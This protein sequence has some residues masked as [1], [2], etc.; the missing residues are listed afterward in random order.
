MATYSELTLEQGASFS[1]NVTVI[2]N[3]N[4]YMNLTNYTANSQMRKSYLATTAYDFTIS[5][6]DAANGKILL[7]MA[8]ANTANI[9]AG[10]YVYDLVI[11]DNTVK[12]R[13]VEGIVTVLPSVTR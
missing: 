11:Q 5:I 1:A 8:S 7:T 13:V 3:Y 9:K 6:T 10:R 2:D 4:Q 12:T